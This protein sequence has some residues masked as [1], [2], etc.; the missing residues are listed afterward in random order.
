MKTKIVCRSGSLKALKKTVSKISKACR[1]TKISHKKS[2]IA[3]KYKCEVLIE[4]ITAAAVN[5]L[6]EIKT[7]AKVSVEVE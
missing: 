7:P 2:R 1:H 3:C 4:D 6:R 5:A